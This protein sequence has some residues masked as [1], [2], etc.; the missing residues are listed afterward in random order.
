MMWRSRLT[1]A[2]S[3]Y[4]RAA[5]EQRTDVVCLDALSI[6]DERL[7]TVAER[8]ALV[9][10][11]LVSRLEDVQVRSGDE[12]LIAQPERRQRDA[13]RRR[14]EDRWVRPREV[15]PQLEAGLVLSEKK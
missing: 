13:V 12:A 6:I 4:S 7:H 14:S 3:P 2:R 11:V 15:A 10:A 8:Q 1:R 5:L 9:R